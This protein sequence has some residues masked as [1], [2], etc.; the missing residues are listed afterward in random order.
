MN[1]E[2]A[3]YMCETVLCANAQTGYFILINVISLSFVAAFKHSWDEKRNTAQIENYQW[4]LILPE[5]VYCGQGD[6]SYCAI[7]L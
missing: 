5:L 3:I 2:I 4:C 1:Q 6:Q 7:E